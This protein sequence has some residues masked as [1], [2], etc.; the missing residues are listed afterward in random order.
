MA[1]RRATES[2]Y[3]RSHRPHEEKT[4]F[5]GP[6]CLHRHYSDCFRSVPCH[7]VPNRAIRGQV[8]RERYANTSQGTKKEQKKRRLASKKNE[9]NALEKSERKAK[10]QAT[11]RHKTMEML[12]QHPNGW[13]GGMDI[14]RHIQTQTVRGAWGC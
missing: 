4:I 2:V 12:W 1:Y 3:H 9:N 6:K 5:P 14:W 11:C 13:V 7:P 10:R 8:V